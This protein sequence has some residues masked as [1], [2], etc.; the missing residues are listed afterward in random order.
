MDRP[1]QNNLHLYIKEMR[2]HS[3]TAVV[4][5]C[6]KSYE[7]A[8]L[9]KAGIQVFDM[10][11]ADGHSPPAEIIQRWLELVDDTFFMGNAASANGANSSSLPC[12]AIHCV[13]GLGRAPQLVT[14]AMIEFANIDAVDA[15]TMI[16]KQRKGAINGKQL[17]YLNE[18][19]RSYKKRRAGG[20]SDSGD[21][22]CIVM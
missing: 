16:R 14:L 7:T 4:R 10:E 22:C 12:I 17:Q 5:A 8:P 2:N 11:Y 6:E 3:V 20:A 9:E 21:G 18:Y 13:A 19:K 15:V 1:R